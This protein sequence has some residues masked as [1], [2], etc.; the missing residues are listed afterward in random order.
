MPQTNVIYVGV[1]GSVLALDRETGAELWRSKLK[2]PGFVNVV[3]DAGQLFATTQGEVFGVSRTGLLS[4]A[5]TRMFCRKIRLRRTRVSRTPPMRIR[6][7]VVRPAQD[8]AA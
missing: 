5:R 3:L 4:T 1:K 7:S 8:R 2:G 6:V